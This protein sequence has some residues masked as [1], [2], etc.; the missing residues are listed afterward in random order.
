[1]ML[2][3]QSVTLDLTTF[4]V[5]SA[6]MQTYKFP[7]YKVTSSIVHFCVIYAL[8]ATEMASSGLHICMSRLGHGG[9]CLLVDRDRCT[10]CRQYYFSTIHYSMIYMHQ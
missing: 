2:R 10:S 4:T 6:N 9:Q 5:F 8:Q 1:M 7:H 3:F